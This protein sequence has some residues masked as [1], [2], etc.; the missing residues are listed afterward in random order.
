MD[1]DFEI[2]NFQQTQLNKPDIL[3]N[4][5]IHN[6]LNKIDNNYEIETNNHNETDVHNED[7]I[8]NT[9]TD[10]HNETDV[11]NNKSIEQKNNIQCV[12]IYN[13][14]KFM[15]FTTKFCINNILLFYKSYF[16]IYCD[17]L[18]YCI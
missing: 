12:K 5:P 17:D 15:V 6:H 16:N 8:E 10:D 11:E 4:N 9:E 1:D 18:C 13:F 14:V 3:I 7:D 2:V